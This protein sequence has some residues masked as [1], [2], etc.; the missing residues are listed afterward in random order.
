[1]G[2]NINMVPREGGN[3]FASTSSLGIERWQSDNFAQELKDVGVT[4]TDKL[5]NYHDFDLSL[6]GPLKK[7]RIWF[8][9]VGRLAQKDKRVANATNGSAF[10]GWNGLGPFTAPTASAAL[11]TACRASQAAAN[12]PTADCP[13]GVS[14]ETINSALGRMTAQVAPKLKLQ[15]YHD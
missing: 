4:S 14:G 5:G 3:R 7:D 2:L 6:G 8:F 13:A 1:G 11:L 15:L 12:G 9:V 10:P